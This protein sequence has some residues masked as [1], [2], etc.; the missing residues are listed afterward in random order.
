VA[1]ICHEN[2]DADTLGG[3]LALADTLT[4]IGADVEVICASGW[5]GTLGFLPGIDLLV[6]APTGRPDVVVLVDCASVERAG[7]GLAAWVHAAAEVIV[8]DH[9]RSNAGYGTINCVD[10]EAAASSEIVSKLISRLVDTPSQ[11][12]AVLLLAGILHDT[13]ALRSPETSPATLRLVADLA[14]LGASIGAISRALFGQRSAAAVRLW[15]H[16]A[17]DL[18][19]AAHGRVVVGV[20]RQE[21]LRA[22]GAALLDAEDLP[23]MLAGIEGADV[24]LLLREVDG[25]TRV[26]IRTTGVVAASEIAALFGGG[27]HDRAAGCTLP[28]SVDAAREQLLRS[29]EQADA[30]TSSRGPDQAIG[31]VRT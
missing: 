18:E 6:H 16:V 24:A 3:G 7:P 31:D 9:H 19:L 29:L 14:E 26:S 17:R 1:V 13:D 8:I 21:M 12:A 5:P 25:G 22:S 11:D 28:V 4:R 30:T 2:P 27:G 15:G 23:D 10:A 20:L